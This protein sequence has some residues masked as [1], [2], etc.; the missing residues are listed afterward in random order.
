MKL[1]F[2]SETKCFTQFSSR[3]LHLDCRQE[4][5]ASLC[6]FKDDIRLCALFSRLRPVIAL[7]FP[8]SLLSI[9]NHKF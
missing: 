4:I 9:D 2:G 6:I 3:E 7:D 5:P 1:P 8:P